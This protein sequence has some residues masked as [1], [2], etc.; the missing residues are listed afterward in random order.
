[1]STVHGY[2]RASTREQADGQ[3][4]DAQRA[5]IAGFCRQRGFAEP[6][7]WLDEGVSASVPLERR[8]RGAQLAASV[9]QG[10]VV[11]AVR[12]DRLFR[13][14][15]HCLRLIDEWTASG[16]A[17]FVLD[18]GGSVL[19]GSSPV[20]RFALT[21]VAAA[22]ELE[23]NLIRERTSAVLQQR[24]RAGLVAGHVPFGYRRDGDRLVPDARER[25]VLDEAQRLRDKGLSVAATARLL[26]E[27]GLIGRR[28]P[29]TRS[30]LDYI[31][32]RPR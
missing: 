20:S 18:F 4:V 29:W 21:A 19:D 8:P 12:L 25:S 1:V 10:D 9:A 13:D 23:R 3:T 6:R 32:R 14:V 15:Q 2:C 24:R 27:R 22:A 28:G 16:V 11:V 5:A 17:V 30:N 7:W 26:N 31:L